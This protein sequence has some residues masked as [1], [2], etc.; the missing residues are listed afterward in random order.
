MNNTQKYTSF[1]DYSIKLSKSMKKFDTVFW[2]KPPKQMGSFSLTLRNI[3]ATIENIKEVQK[4]RDEMRKRTTLDSETNKENKSAGK[5]SEQISSIKTELNQSYVRLKDEFFKQMDLA[6]NQC[7]EVSRAIK[8]KDETARYNEASKDFKL[9]VYESRTEK[10]RIPF[11]ERDDLVQLRQD[12]AR[13]EHEEQERQID[14]ITDFELQDAN[15]LEN[16]LSTLSKIL[17]M[18]QT[19]DLSKEVKKEIAQIKKVLPPKTIAITT[20]GLERLRHS[21]HLLLDLEQISEIMKTSHRFMGSDGKLQKINNQLETLLPLLEQAIKEE[22]N[23]NMSIKQEHDDIRSKVDYAAEAI[24]TYGDILDKNVKLEQEQIQIRNNT[25]E[26]YAENARLKED[27]KKA[28]AEA[29]EIQKRPVDRQEWNDDFKVEQLYE[30]A[31]NDRQAVRENEAYMTDK[32]S[33][34]AVS[35]LPLEY[36]DMKK[37]LQ[38]VSSLYQMQ[39]SQSHELST[40]GMS[41]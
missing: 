31:K 13:Q 10:F 6:G 8:D 32:M 24:K 16:A 23:R 2:S 29:Q 14:S 20:D 9:M 22:K 3:A 39:K 18:T 34:K 38:S 41:K 30:R 37:R 26:L 19:D 27:E 25:H 7:K 1:V 5:V 21:S 11:N 15:K 35:A 40:G 36:T 28:N 12:Q 17:A 33:E 4:M